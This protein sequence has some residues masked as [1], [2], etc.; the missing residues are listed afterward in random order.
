[1]PKPEAKESGAP[2]Q[3]FTYKKYAK[4][5]DSRAANERALAK[6][7]EQ[8]LLWRAQYKRDKGVDVPQYSKASTPIPQIKAPY[9]PSK[10]GETRRARGSGVEVGGVNTSTRKPTTEREETESLKQRQEMIKGIISQLEADFKTGVAP[11]LDRFKPKSFWQRNIADKAKAV[12][13][14]VV[15]DVAGR[16]LDLI[17]RPG[18]AAVGGMTALVEMAQGRPSTVAELRAEGKKLSPAQAAAAQAEYDYWEKAKKQGPI[19]RIWQG[20]QGRE[21]YSFMEPFTQEY[22]RA[23][24]Y[25]PL[26]GPQKIV[27]TAAGFA[28]DV[29]IDPL[30]AVTAGVVAKGA[31]VLRA[32]RNAEHVLESARATSLATKAARDTQDAVKGAK[33]AD[34]VLARLADETPHDWAA[35]RELMPGPRVKELGTGLPGRG[36]ELTDEVQSA[37]RVEEVTAKASQA[38]RI[39]DASEPGFRALRNETAKAARQVQSAKSL[40][41]K[42]KG[43]EDNL[44]ATVAKHDELLNRMTAAQHL[45][46]VA[47]ATPVG[48]GKIAGLEKRVERL[49]KLVQKNPG[50][51]ALARRMTAVHSELQ[52]ARVAAIPDNSAQILTFAEKIARG[53]AVSTIPKATKEAIGNA[54][55]TIQEQIIAL[56]K[57][58]EASGPKVADGVGE[59]LKGATPPKLSDEISRMIVEKE[60]ATTHAV[61]DTA[62]VKQAA[63][64]VLA[65]PVNA[66]QTAIDILNEAGIFGRPLTKAGIRSRVAQTALR[67]VGEEGVQEAAL[68]RTQAKVG[69]LKKAGK[70]LTGAEQR[71]KLFDESLLEEILPTTEAMTKILE[72]GIGKRFAIRFNGK[73][74]GDFAP[75][76][77]ALRGMYVP[78][79]LVGRLG[80]TGP[81]GTFAKAF[82]MGSHF[83]DET[84]YIRQAA[85]N[86]GSATHIEFAN[87]VM[88]TF[89]NTITHAESKQIRRAIEGGYTLENPHLDALRVQAMKMSQDIF[90]QQAALGKYV[91]GEKVENYLYHYY[92]SRNKKAIKAFKDARNVDIKAGRKGATV[93]TAA[94]AGLKPEDRIDRILIMQH[95]DYVRDLQ[96]ANFRQ[97]VISNF[98]VKTD[99]AALANGLG[100]E[101][102]SGKSMNKP[103][104]DVAAAENAK[105]YLAPEIHDTFKTMDNLMGIGH[106][107]EADG[108][109]GAYDA[110]VRMF[111]TS[112]TIANP[113]NW[114]NNTIGDFFLNYMDGVRSPSWYKKAA[115]ILHVQ[116][117]APL[118]SVSIARRNV[119][120]GQILDDFKRK[121]PSGGF[122]RSEGMGH[123]S[124]L[125]SKGLR[126][127]PGRFVRGGQNLYETREEWVRFAHYLH[128]VDDEA[129]RLVGRGYKWDKAY[130]GATEL[131]AKRV[132]KWNIDYTAITPFERNIRKRFVP[133]Y[134]FMRK[135]TPLMLEGMITRPG[136]MAHYDRS[137]RAVE[138]LLGVPKEEDDG[139]IWPFW[140][141]Q[142]GV[143]RLTDEA[144]PLYLRDPTPLNVVN[145]LLGGESMRAPFT[146]A[147][148]QFAPPIR[149]GIEL[150]SGK[151]LF[152][153]RKIDQ[154]GDWILGQVPTVS[155]GARMAG[156]PLS[157][158]KTSASEGPGTAILERLG[159]IGIPIGRMTEQRQQAAL[160]GQIDPIEGVFKEVNDAIAPYKITKTTSKKNG[161]YYLVKDPSGEIIAREHDF[162]TAVRK[163][164]GG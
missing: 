123:I 108:F 31:N 122:I 26:T 30:N 113:G 93:D 49:N 24:D 13:E 128:A 1:M 48:L 144:E 153:D 148:N 133:F 90:D 155:I 134:T 60:N 100:L 97:G 36:F 5:P 95:R 42:G 91:P 29:A 135:A 67:M 140:A 109:L 77:A 17:G 45:R 32:P 118:R 8:I 40:L 115:G 136:R 141:K 66:Q 12:G 4:E 79:E 78:F 159:T 23:N 58:A 131:A 6:A 76:G 11:D 46:D 33:I 112:A 147:L 7:N 150:A 103:F 82:R 68:V 146:N 75:I 125:G 163:A 38:A 80:A 27:P 18:N 39:T 52:A 139:T 3:Y 110:M 81:G 104:Q 56:M 34:N 44:A 124:R 37:A 59:S 14:S 114:V 85:E 61:A 116:E 84:N 161:T 20:L 50:N 162:I 96:R 105:W 55:P 35:P 63:Q 107:V 156:H 149:G 137:K 106:N 157:P 22:V 94:K 62:T 74:L 158:Q 132:A 19:N 51:E 145:R 126:G 160:Q 119:D 102:V 120:A 101:E 54:S 15:G 152:N 98:G 2:I 127:I 92:H 71:A 164:S 117:Q 9:R 142:Q 72:E 130:E 21:I 43:S 151:T 28:T 57:E 16:A 65:D 69:E 138:Q 154:W 83:P 73:D 53:E 121:A 99:N 89:T 86:N 10:P 129:R 87:N 143:T 41:K 88:K 70:V 111:K 64:Q 47:R 25:Q